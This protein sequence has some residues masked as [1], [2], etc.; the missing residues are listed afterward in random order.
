MEKK[1]LGQ[2]AVNSLKILPLNDR[3]LSLASA[4]DS[5]IM[6]ILG[7]FAPKNPKTVV[8]S[9]NRSDSGSS[10]CE[11]VTPMHLHLL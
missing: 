6:E 2:T 9:N 8:A 4:H 5:E 7:H 1:H 11:M 3:F 10:Q